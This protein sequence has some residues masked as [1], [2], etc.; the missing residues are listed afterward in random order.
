MIVVAG[1]HGDMHRGNVFGGIARQA[2]TRSF[3]YPDRDSAS[4]EE[5]KCQCQTRSEMHP[6]FNVVS[7]MEKGSDMR[8]V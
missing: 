6:A 3:R 1:G 5:M 2:L 4:I 8:G 7:M